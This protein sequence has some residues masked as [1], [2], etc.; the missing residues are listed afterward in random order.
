M[1]SQ[2]EQ[3]VEI[4]FCDC[5]PYKRAKLSTIN[6]LMADIAG[7]AFAS[8]GMNHQYLWDHGFVFLLSKVSLSIERMPI[9]DERVRLLTWE[10]EVQ[11][12]VYLRDFEIRTM[13]HTLLCSATS[14]WILVNPHTRQILRPSEFTG[15]LYPMP[16]R[17]AA[18][19]PCKKLRLTDGIDA[20][21][22]L[23]R[24]SDLDGNGHVYN[25]VY[26]DIAVD[27]L[28]EELRKKQLQTFQINFNHEAKLQDEIQLLLAVEGSAA[29][30]KGFV[31]GQDCFICTLKYSEI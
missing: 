31:D 27:V 26:S 19:E 15:V 24:Y 22:R 29:T 4:R 11:R 23:V 14:S 16:D 13:D 28:P 18:A 9:A 1:D 17:L 21:T 5:D 25:A 8:R 2:F 10:R 7:V 20:G 12:A 30:V 6:K 3:Q